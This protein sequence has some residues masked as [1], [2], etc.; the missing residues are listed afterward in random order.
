MRRSL[1][2]LLGTLL[3]AT[4]A[5]AQTA[6]NA[7]PAAPSNATPPTAASPAPTAAAPASPAPAAAAP[8]ATVPNTIG[9]RV[10]ACAICHGKDGEGA[11]KN[12][13][14]PRLAGKPVE[15]LY[16]QLLGFREKRRASSPIMTYMVGGLSDTYLHEI[17]GYYAALRPPFPTPSPRADTDRL[18][19][20]QTLAMRGDPARDIPSCASCHGTALAGLLPAVPG[21]IG[22][23]P[24]YIGAQLGAWKDGK[25]NSAA[26]DCMAR[27]ASRLSGEDISAVAAF[28][29]TQPA[30]P[31]TP[32]AAAGSLKLPL[33]CGGAPR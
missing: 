29:A 20:G 18:T 4:A 33:E 8:G 25:R 23:Y 16:N 2:I 11:R 31:D 24:D 14:Y 6:P 10:A 1:G 30:S 13:Y 5:L 27:I 9:Q 12:D 3:G 17:A 28:L 26:P 22:L 7:S 19:L 21:L 32:L 15:Y